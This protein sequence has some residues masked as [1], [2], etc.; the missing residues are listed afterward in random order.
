MR[1]PRRR[2]GVHFRGIGDRRPPWVGRRKEP[3]CVFPPGRKDLKLFCGGYTHERRELR[4]A[5][6][7]PG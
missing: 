1:S 2:T 6:S 7:G 5:L 3:G 4:Y